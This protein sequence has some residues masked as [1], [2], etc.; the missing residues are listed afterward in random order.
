M[1]FRKIAPI[2]ALPG[3]P[4]AEDQENAPQEDTKRWPE[5]IPGLTGGL[6]KGKRPARRNK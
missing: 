2:P 3:F 6:L 4:P 5:P 1:D